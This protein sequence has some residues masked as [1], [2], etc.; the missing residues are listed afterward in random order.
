MKDLFDLREMLEE[1]KN[2]EKIHRVKPVLLNQK[3]INEMREKLN[4]LKREGKK[5]T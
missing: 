2:D 5:V 4:R 1:I 3:E